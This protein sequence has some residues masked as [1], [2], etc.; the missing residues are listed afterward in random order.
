MTTSTSEKTLLL[1]DNDPHVYHSARFMLQAAG[2]RVRS[3]QSLDEGRQIIQNDIVHAAVIDLRLTDNQQA[4][5]ISGFTL[6]NEL[7]AHIPFVI[8]TAYRDIDNLRH[9]LSEIGAKDVIDKNAAD[10]SEQLLK[11]VDN[12][13]SKHVAQN[14]HLKLSGTVTVETIASRIEVSPA[15]A[16]VSSD[17][18]CAILRTLFAEALQ[19]DLRLLFD[20]QAPNGFVSSGAVL[21]C[22]YPIYAQGHQG[23][24]MVVKFSSR[25]RTRHEEERYANLLRYLGGTRLAILEEKAYSRAVGA[26]CYRFFGQAK[27][28]LLRHFSDLLCDFEVDAITLSEKLIHFLSETFAIIY[29]TAK[30]KKIDLYRHYAD[31]FGLT[32]AKLHTA[33][34]VLSLDRREGLV[35]W[36]ALARHL[37]D[38]IAWIAPNDRW[39]NAERVTQTCLCHGDLH[40]R[41][42]L[43]DGDLG[44][45]LIDFERAEN[46]HCLRD[47]AELEVDIKFQLCAQ[48]DSGEYLIFETILLNQW[49]PE[50]QVPSDS[51]A[52]QLRPSA[53]RALQIVSHLRSFIL[54]SFS[55][56]EAAQYEAA[57]LIT[58]LNF[59][60]LK[61]TPRHKQRLAYLSA[62]LLCEKINDES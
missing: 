33:V 22:V 45:W 4:D 16:K 13:F 29:A 11:A 8:F 18:I 30:A 53:R 25:E 28:D 55:A 26:L 5:D 37:P 21:L 3:A 54:H 46:S 49:Q 27:P 14:F 9:A 61:S 23:A 58:T 38:P 44:F 56:R 20:E 40:G 43:V 60:R 59:M 51:T 10:A 15:A 42:I 19:I 62:A 57:L 48:I 31:C 41:N 36:P 2:Y 47:I 12:M 7:P 52:V 39:R 34:E 1:A 35:Y 17:D 24:P 6:G 50:R 32:A